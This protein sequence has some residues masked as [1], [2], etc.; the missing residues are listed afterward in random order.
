MGGWGVQVGWQGTP[1][2]PK[3]SSGVSK[4]IRRWIF[5]VNLQVQSVKSTF[6][7]LCSKSL[8]YILQFED[9]LRTLPW[10]T[11]SMERCT[12]FPGGVPVDSVVWSIGE[13]IADCARLFSTLGQD[14]EILEESDYV[15]LLH[16]NSFV[17]FVLEN[18]RS[19]NEGLILS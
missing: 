8:L 11:K 12:Y 1:V 14:E 10:E 18:L 2:T 15:K 3:S 5:F 7:V 16:I 19:F 4:T 13:N 9:F 17:G 6:I